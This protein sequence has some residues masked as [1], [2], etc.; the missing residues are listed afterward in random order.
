MLIRSGSAVSVAVEKYFNLVIPDCGQTNITGWPLVMYGKPR[1]VRDFDNC[2]WNVRGFTKSQGSVGGKILSEKWPTTDY[3]KT[4]YLLVFKI[5]SILLSLCISFWFRIK[6][7]CI[8]T[9]ITD[10][11]TSTG[12]LWVTLNTG[13]SASTR[14]GN[15]R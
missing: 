5:V 9:P 1:N 12:M 2:Q 13:T 3:C 14:W 6:H 15:V 10:N 11:N 7:C 4:A 8:P